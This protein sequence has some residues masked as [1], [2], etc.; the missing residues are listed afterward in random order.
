MAGGACFGAPAPVIL[1]MSALR[2]L[3]LG[4][5]LR[6]DLCSGFKGPPVA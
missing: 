1:R 3:I 2:N 6:I 5:L 4:R